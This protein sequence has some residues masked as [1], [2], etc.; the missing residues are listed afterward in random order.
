M[1]SLK[2]RDVKL[3]TRIESNARGRKIEVQNVKWLQESPNSL[4][5]LESS[6]KQRTCLC[7]YVG[8]E[9]CFLTVTWYRSG[10]Y[11]KRLL[12]LCILLC[13]SPKTLKEYFRLRHHLHHR[14]GIVNG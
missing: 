9:I 1:T 8:C 10:G 11:R 7:S 13:F 2:C 6:K 5:V 3:R 14:Q 12:K 4:G